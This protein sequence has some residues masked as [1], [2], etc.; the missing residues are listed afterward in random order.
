MMQ[1]SSLLQ[2]QF[3][4]FHPSV[5]V[6]LLLLCKLPLNI[7]VEPGT[8]CAIPR[9][10]IPKKK[11]EK[12][13]N[14]ILTH[15]KTLQAYLTKTVLMLEDNTHKEHQPIPQTSTEYSQGTSEENIKTT[16]KVNSLIH[17]CNKQ[18]HF[19]L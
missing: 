5:V 11:E 8:N 13:N 4:R 2:Y 19:K 14:K 12:I 6:K 10:F 7:L 1:N 16:G 18:T 3:Y 15:S 9:V 17:Q